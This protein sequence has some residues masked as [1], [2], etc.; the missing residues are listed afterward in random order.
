[1]SLLTL[2]GSEYTLSA[3]AWSAIM[4]SVCFPRIFLSDFVVKNIVA[5]DPFSKIRGSSKD[6]HTGFLKNI[7]KVR[8]KF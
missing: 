1:M 4:Y 7:V 2:R 3:V 5:T 8:F 6:K